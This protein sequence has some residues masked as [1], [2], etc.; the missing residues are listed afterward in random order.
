M[1]SIIRSRE[2][3]MNARVLSSLIFV[4]LGPAPEIVLPIFRAESLLRK[5][6][7]Y[8]STSQPDLDLDKLPLKFLS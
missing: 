1:T 4:S 8:L 5:F 3:R 2:H 7:S 6:L